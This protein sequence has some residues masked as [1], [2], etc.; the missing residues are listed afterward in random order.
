MKK[1][2]RG[3]CPI[4]PVTLNDIMAILKSDG[5]HVDEVT[6]DHMQVSKDNDTYKIEPSRGKSLFY[7]HKIDKNDPA[8]P[9]QLLT[10]ICV[11][12]WGELVS[13]CAGRTLM[14]EDMNFSQ[15]YISYEKTTTSSESPLSTEDL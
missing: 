3:D 14:G 4:K 7:V 13:L 9:T 6:N 10:P 15:Q 2:Y 11:N 5:F 12:K 1:L 8:K